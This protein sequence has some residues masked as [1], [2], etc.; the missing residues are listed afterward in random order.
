[1][2]ESKKRVVSQMSQ[3]EHA[4]H[5]SMWAGSKEMQETNTYVY[6]DGKFVIEKLTYPPAL[7]KI[8]DETIVNATDHHTHYSKL[9]TKIKIEITDSGVISIYNNGPGISIEKVKNTDG[10]EMYTPQLIASE[11]LAGD[12]LYDEG[13]NTKGGTNGVGLKLAVAFSDYLVVET[14]DENKSIYYKQKFTHNKIKII[15]EEPEIK[16]ITKKTSPYTRITFMPT[17][18]DF[19]INISDFYPVLYKLINTRSWISAAFTSAK[20]YFNNAELPVENFSNFCQMLTEKEVISFKM[21]SESIPYSWDV[22]VSISDGSDKNFSIINGIYVSNGG[23]HIKYIQKCL[24]DGLKEK[25]TKEIKQ[26]GATFNKNYITN[27]L[28]IFMKGI[29]RSPIFPGQTKETL[30]DPI[31]KFKSYTI[32]EKHLKLVWELIQDI[33]LDMYQA[34]QIGNTKSRTK[35]TKIRAPGYVEADLCRDAKNCHLCGLIITEGLSASGTAI[36][37][38]LDPKTTEEF[39]YKYF[40]IY[41]IQGVP[42]NT[43]K[44]STEIYSKVPEKV[45]DKVQEK[46]PDKITDKVQEKVPDKVTRV[47]G[48]V[49]GKVAKVPDRSKIIRRIPK[50]K[51]LENERIKTMIDILGLDFNKKYLF[52]DPTG[53]KEYRSLR[54]GFMVC[55]MDQDL[56]GFNIFGLL[57]TFIVAYWPDLAKRNFI[58]R[59]NTPVIRVY[60]KANSKLP[61]KEFYT[62]ASYKE[63]SNSFPLVNKYK[64]PKYYKGLGTHNP[65]MGE[66]RQ[67]FKNIKEKICI[68][69]L[70][71]Y[72]IDAMYIYYGVET[73]ERKLALSTPVSREPVTGLNIPLSQLYEIDT[74]SY[75][76]DNILRKLLNGID[77]FVSSRRK[78]FYTAR[79]FLKEDIKVDGLAGLVVKEANY[80]HGQASL[81]GTISKMAQG[82]PTA[83]NLPLLLPLGA[84][85]TRNM[86]YKDYSSSRYISTNL[87]WRLANTLFVPK[88]DFILPYEVDAGVRYEPI[89]YA[90]IIPYVLCETNELPATGWA[91]S[92]HARNID[93]IFKNVR[94]MINGKITKCGPLSLWAKDFK[95]RI[96]E[97]NNRSYSV[98]E[99]TYDAETNTI[100]ITELPFGVYSDSY[101]NGGDAKI[102]DKGIQSKKIVADVKDRTTENGVDI[103]IYLTNDAKDV[104]LSS[105]TK[106]GNDKFDAIEDYF[107]L[108]TPIYDRINLINEHGEVKEFAT[109]EDVFDHWYK[110]RKDLYTVRVDREIILIKL[111]IKLIENMQ[112]FSESHNTYNINSNK[113]DNYIEELLTTHN[114]KKFD[115]ATLNNPKFT[116]LNLLVD[117]ITGQTATYDYLKNMSYRDL[118]EESYKKRNNEKEKLKTRLKY[119]EDNEGAFKGAKIWLAELNDLEKAIKDGIKSDWF[120]G[121]NDHIFE[122][123]DDEPDTNI[124]VRQSKETKPKTRKTK[125]L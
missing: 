32:S 72:A 92:T 21:E 13:N 118:T 97:Y 48:K 45:T 111:E 66:V 18:V 2:E 51:I 103:T 53:D 65:K 71:D 61:V 16:K 94:D 125:K 40:G 56:D 83:R 73:S 7:L 63:W 75:Q 81:E 124:P 120:Y 35:R 55:L 33:I 119:L 38:L 117:T 42:V 27:N 36:T 102:T 104:L 90:P 121:E 25:V 62:E 20:V 22:C 10:I 59:I 15:A 89:Y 84:F 68:Y 108:K 17:Y 46:V 9:V 34:T 28:F 80:H 106:Y 87:N 123:D 85:G 79:N 12:N 39:S 88:D 100:N 50:K 107:E 5:K 105:D 96:V 60:S 37:G 69:N 24:I 122:D 52:N 98:G 57:A 76:R 58:R 29:I 101:I 116:E 1:M 19:S 86:G 6:C 23:S 8:I 74:K 3:L 91:I 99:Y 64:D 14:F 31:E 93:D 43:L 26:Y 113:N 47:P 49:P 78:V 115:K 44:E 109:Y 41:S 110:F 11:F 70:D 4:R 54:Y 114:Y 82:F 77:G 30:G 67:M 95:G 112:R